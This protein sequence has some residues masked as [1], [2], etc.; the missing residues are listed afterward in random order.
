M[1]TDI[2]SEYKKKIR[3]YTH[4]YI[5]KAELLVFN[6][7]GA[8]A[9]KINIDRNKLMTAGISYADSTSS[10]DSFD[11][12]AAVIGSA[13]L[14]VDNTSDWLKD[15]NLE[16]MKCVLYAGMQMDD[17]TIEY[18]Q[19]G[20]YNMENPQTKATTCTL[21]LLDN[22]SLFEKPLVD[23]NLNY[24]LQAY[25]ALSKICTFCGVRLKM[26]SFTNSEVILEDPQDDSLTCLD[27]V[28]YIAQ[29]ACCYAKCDSEGELVFGWYDKNNINNNLN[30]GVLSD[31]TTGDNADGG[32]LEDYATGDKFDGGNYGDFSSYHHFYMLKSTPTIYANETYISGCKITF[33]NDDD[34]GIVEAGSEGYVLE[35]KD[36]P[37]ITNESIAESVKMAIL[38]KAVGLKFRKCSFTTMYDPTVEA[39]DVG[40]FSDYKGRTYPIIISNLTANIAG[41][42][43][44]SS[45]SKTA[46]KQRATS[47]ANTD[48]RIEAAVKREKNAREK[49]VEILAQELAASSGMFE[50]DVKTEDGGTIRYIHDKKLLSDSTVVIKITMKAIGISNDG[51]KTYPYGIDVSGTAILKEIYAVGINASYITTGIIE[52]IKIIMSQGQVGGWN[53]D[54][55]AIYKDVTVGTDLYRVFIQPPDPSSPNETWII[56]CQKNYVGNFVLYGNGQAKLGNIRITDKNVNVTDVSANSTLDS[57]HLI[58]YGNDGVGRTSYNKDFC[59]INGSLTVTGDK[60]R[61]VQTQNYG[62][63]LL[64][65]FETPS[66]MFGDVGEGVIDDTGICVIFIEDIFYET[67]DTSNKY[68]IFLQPYDKGSCYVKERNNYSF[69]VEGTQGLKF[70]WHIYAHQLGYNAYR[71][72]QPEN[73]DA[74]DNALSILE[75]E[76]INNSE[77]I[78][79]ILDNINIGG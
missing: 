68:Q 72:E 22:M 49:A 24:P 25:E 6:D 40:F 60:N 35:I 58:F 12:G 63:R 7:S 57:E 67:I 21:S 31:Y 52:G 55:G 53:I 13:Q 71:N 26:T 78:A 51:G 20:V 66:P 42:L 34:T 48:A 17:G 32:T 54:S 14:V 29:I 15:Y 39:G 73:R 64:N 79:G 28:S 45:D 11:V 2:S 44:L 47:K 65:A 3:E 69:I 33:K 37:F 59:Q 16:M 10:T 70:G 74:S 36:N 18:I 5:P 38:G 61:L 43:R 4:D 50:T 19:K 75:E 23:V 30:G 8:V 76:I 41:K 27:A 46:S 9:E 77:M 56:S 62:S 1:V